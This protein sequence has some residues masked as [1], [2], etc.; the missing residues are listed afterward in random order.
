[1]ASIY[2]KNDAARRAEKG[3]LYDFLA[4]DGSENR[5]A[6]KIKGWLGPTFLLCVKQMKK[7]Y[8]LKP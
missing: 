7:C 2:M 5:E 3:I 8:C 6:A 1:M 4:A